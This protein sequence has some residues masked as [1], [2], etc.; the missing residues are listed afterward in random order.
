MIVNLPVVVRLGTRQRMSESSFLTGQVVRLLLHELLVVSE[1]IV[2]DSVS[3]RVHLI[4][5]IPNIQ[6][7]DAVERG[8]KR[9]FIEV[10]VSADVFLAVLPALLFGLK[11]H[12]DICF[13]FVSILLLLILFGV[14]FK[15]R[16]FLVFERVLVL[17]ILSDRLLFLILVQLLH[18][19]FN[20]PTISAH[21]VFH[22]ITR[23]LFLSLHVLKSHICLFWEYLTESV[24]FF[25]L[26]VAVTA[27]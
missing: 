7:R 3:A 26:L 19:A 2:A 1:Q 18:R 23:K 21:K 11:H 17:S 5:N 12:A 25:P 8:I 20:V 10:T 13:R 27:F 14:L 24:T 9:T 22:D 6:R 16:L 15:I 4:Q